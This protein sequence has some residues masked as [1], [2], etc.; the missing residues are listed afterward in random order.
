LADINGIPPDYHSGLQEVIDMDDPGS[1]YWTNGE[2]TCSTK[3]ACDFTVN[4]LFSE[5]AFW[6]A[7]DTM[8]ASI[9]NK[10]L[11]YTAAPGEECEI[12]ETLEE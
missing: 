11:F 8:A 6:C 4:C 1:F 7:T 5:G 2:V 3:T 10:E 9:P 12:T